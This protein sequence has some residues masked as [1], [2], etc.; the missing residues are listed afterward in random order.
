MRDC[1]ALV[2]YSRILVV[3]MMHMWKLQCTVPVCV[4]VHRWYSGT[5]S[6]ARMLDWVLAIVATTRNLLQWFRLIELC[7]WL[8][9]L[10]T[11]RVCGLDCRLRQASFAVRTFTQ[12]VHKHVNLLSWVYIHCKEIVKSC[13]IR[14]SNHKIKY[15]FIYIWCIINENNSRNLVC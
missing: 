6:S 11:N 13:N 9:F 14:A 10:P 15:K 4:V 2:L 8:H 7:L 3:Y 12:T 5:I 1:Y